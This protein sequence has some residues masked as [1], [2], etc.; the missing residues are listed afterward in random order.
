MGCQGT[1][2]PWHCKVFGKIQAKER[3]KIIV[4][5]QLCPFCLLHNKARPCGAK[6][7]PVNPACHMP[8]CKGKHIRK[9]H[10][11]LKDVFKE[12][13]QV[14]LVQGGDEW[15]E[16]EEAW[17]V[18]EEGEAMIVGTIQQED[19]CSWQ[20]ASPG[21]SS[22]RK[23]KME[24]IMS[25]RARVRTACHRRQGRSSAVRSCALPRRKTRMQKT[26]KTAGGPPSQ[27]TCR[28]RGEKK[29][30]S[31]SSSW[32]DHGTERR[33]CGEAGRGRQQ[34]GPA[35]QKRCDPGKQTSLQQRQEE[36]RREDPQGKKWGER[37][38]GK[39][40]GQCTE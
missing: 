31:S 1:H 23:K 24:P 4:D 5:N 20:D 32:G 19:N 36:K 30:T 9:L 35:D 26:W 22:T 29:S 34:G 27:R 39:E 8:N 12:E 6:Q 37:Q 10:E 18:D 3:E 38:A 15:E 33:S 17:E 2:P 21:W 16:S 13:N 11:L 40:G 7:R 14:H 28:S 25:E